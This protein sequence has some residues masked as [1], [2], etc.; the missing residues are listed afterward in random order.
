MSRHNDTSLTEAFE[1]CRQ[2]TRTQARNF[3]CGLKLTPEPK[4]SALYVIYAWMRRADDLV[5]DVKGGEDE[6][7]LRERVDHFR[8][9]TDAALDGT[10][11]DDDPVWVS[12]H[13]VVRRFELPRHH[14]Y[15]M[16]AGQLDDLRIHQYDSFKQLG[17]YCYRVASTVGLI[18]ISIWGYT[19]EA[20]HELAIQRGM[21]FQLTNIIR[22]VR[23]DLEMGRRYLPAEDLERHGLDAQ[24][25]L[26]WR[27]PDAC[28]R[29]ILEQ[30]ERAETYYRS[31]EPLDDLI[32]PAC[33]PA[34][35]AM[36]S[37]Y[38][39]TLEKI[40]RD[41]RRIVDDARVALSPFQKSTIA[42]QA[43]WRSLRTRNVAS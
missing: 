40:R 26:H 30:V 23:E 25:L 10:P 14:F 17:D 42:L 31:S 36:T 18:C 21:A 27:P 33:V 43:K 3:Y 22:D 4:R 7:V 6:E 29:C 35:W 32:D 16:I 41:P 12:L 1:H 2:I 37:I 24:G 8:A 11:V 34:L 28:R 13:D 19:D 5:D 38:R 39:Q 9:A 15:D 20:A